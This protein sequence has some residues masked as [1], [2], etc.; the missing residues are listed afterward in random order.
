[1]NPFLLRRVTSK[2]ESEAKQQKKKCWPFQTQ[3][4][5]SHSKD[6]D[7]PTLSKSERQKIAIQGWK[8]VK[9]IAIAIEFMAANGEEVGVNLCV[10]V[11]F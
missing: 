10:C 2:D 8:K 6:Q 1:M 3:T 11:C 4:K 9:K 7:I 5:S